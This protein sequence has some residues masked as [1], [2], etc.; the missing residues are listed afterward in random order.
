LE[1]FGVQQ[2]GSVWK[3]SWRPRSA[4]DIVSL[5]GPDRSTHRVAP[6]FWLAAPSQQS[7]SPIL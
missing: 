4:K 5:M 3:A 7:S 6:T 1:I 2:D